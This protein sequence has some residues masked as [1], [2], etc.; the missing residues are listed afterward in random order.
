MAAVAVQNARLFQQSDWVAEVVHE[1]RTPLTAILSYAD[2]L[3]RPDLDGSLREQAI[4][5]IQSETE[6]VSL[7][8]TQFL[9]LA[10]LESGRITMS[11]DEIEV[12][13]LVNRAVDVIRP[14]AEQEDRTLSVA[15][16]DDLPRTIGDRQR[17][18]QVLLNLLSNAVKY[19]DPGDTIT[20]KAEARNSGFVIM[21]GDTGPGIPD[22]QIPMLFQK[23]R[24]LPN[25]AGKASGTG[26]G[27]VVA[28]QIVEAHQG[29]I[30][31]ESDL[32]Q[33]SR[34]FVELPVLALKADI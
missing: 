14:N 30:W 17:L 26:L 5:T 32:G 13:N 3:L 12:G 20:V 2:L 8:A 27:L 22:A 33:G 15:V 29:R 25:S 19:T 11:R 7:L 34:F 16:A 24:R 28:R 18:H 6:R 10:R 1:I 23:F 21:V 31:V 9:E 4:K